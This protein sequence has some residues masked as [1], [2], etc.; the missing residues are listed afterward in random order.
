[1]PVTRFQLELRRPLAG[2]K[3]FGQVGAYEELRGKLFFDV[4]PSHESNE[5]VG[6]IG[7]VA[8]NASERV[9]FSS[10]VVILKPVDAANGNG[11]VLFDVLNR[12]KRL[13]LAQ[14]NNAPPHK[15]IYDTPRLEEIEVGHG[16]LM[17]Q[18][19]TVI[20]VGWQADVPPFQAL[21]RLTVPEAMDSD[22]RR[23]TG[24]IFS[25]F[26]AAE[27]V[28]NFML[29][30]RDHTAH[31]ALEMNQTDALLTVR[32][33]PD[34]D[35]T[36][37]SRDQWRFGRVVEGEYV[38][39]P[40]Y[41]TKEGGFE[42]GLMYQL[43]Y[44]TVGAPV[45]GLGFLVMRD[46]ISWLKYGSDSDGNPSVG[47]IKHAYGFGVS[48]SGRF[49]RNFIYLDLNLD[50][51]GREA[52]DG[53]IPHVPGGMRGEFNQ[54]F[55]Q[56]SKDL[57]TMMA[58]LFPFTPG[59]SVD[60]VTE[61]RGALMQRIADRESPLKVFFSNTAAEYWRSDASLVHT[62]PDAT[63]D[64]DPPEN[65]RIYALAGCQHGH[66][67]WPPTD[68]RSADNLRGQNLVNS[69]DYA[70][71]MRAQLENLHQWAANNVAPPDS[72]YPRL[73]DETGLTAEQVAAKFDAIPNSNRP[74]HIP[75]PKRI[76]FG[77]N[78]DET[79]TRTLPPVP[80]KSYGAIVSDVDSDGN[81]IAGLMLPD[82][83][84]PLATSTPWNLRHPTMGAPD[85]VIGLTGG[86][87]GST[88]PFPLT[89]EDRVDSADPRMSIQE[90]YAS[91]E[92][93]LEKV[94]SAAEVLVEQREILEFDVERCVDR[95]GERWD[96]F[97]SRASR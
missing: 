22:G 48:Q 79:L 82:I 67:D 83:L 57:P 40:S 85:Q 7:L 18:G 95:A 75:I 65:A 24:K 90:R 50:E 45:M 38:E 55:G 68:R 26:Q 17:D 97:T 23:L 69:I 64:I 6:D 10:D 80:G 20:W 84:V 11:R 13:A 77:R 74:M 16:W 86:L 28:D 27:K 59:E 61:E 32:D 9:E 44:T 71:L 58:Q 94:R 34:S 60:P 93:Y 88:L 21:L 43:T 42:P 70:P 49:L 47:H 8:M 33:Q 52:F 54:R 25:Q 62:D 4:D 41:V 78:D 46:S 53:I 51:E 91:K 72:Q 29:S 19:Y 89:R 15:V 66:G 92:A 36:T 87:T 12:G 39:D 3:S 14:F 73:D 1:L 56:P 31:P 2:G 81:E 30:D 35:P 96:W 5:R 63:F 76:D 37:I